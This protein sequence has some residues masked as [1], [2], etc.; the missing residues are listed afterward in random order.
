[1][2]GMHEWWP[3]AGPLFAVWVVFK[4]AL[5]ALFVTG[6]VLGV[7]WLWR[8]TSDRRRPAA[9]ERESPLDILRARYARGEL[10]REEFQAMRQEL[11][12]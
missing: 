8:E 6:L 4:V 7:R 12:R 2:Y 9:L 3:A 1:M 11:E 10:S 5:W